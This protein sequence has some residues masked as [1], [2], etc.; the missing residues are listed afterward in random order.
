MSTP[1]DPIQTR[2]KPFYG[3]C[4]GVSAAVSRSALYSV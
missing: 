2:L 3:S 4:Q 1:L